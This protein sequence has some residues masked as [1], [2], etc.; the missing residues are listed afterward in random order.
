MKYQ[1]KPQSLANLKPAKKGEVRNPQGIN[2]KRPWTD[3]MF[4][5]GEELLE[6]TDEGKQIRKALK[7]PD[8]ATWADAAVRRL[9]REALKG[10]IQAIKE[11]ADR[12]EGKPPE[13]IE[14]AGVQ[15]QEININV[16]F[17]RT[18]R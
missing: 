8:T 1:P 6:A 2:R 12:T 16:K 10:N 14:I 18:K 9:M 4:Q 17:D 11:M 7:L 5:H 3:R 13:R 15:R